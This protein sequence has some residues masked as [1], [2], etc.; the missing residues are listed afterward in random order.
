MTVHNMSGAAC[1]LLPLVVVAMM[2][3]ACGSGKDEAANKSA[4]KAPVGG[5]SFA[6][7]LAYVNKVRAGEKAL[8]ATPEIPLSQQIAIITATCEVS[9]QIPGTP[10]EV[11]MFALVYCP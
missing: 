6:A 3:T 1:R 8:Y 10:S 5:L 9:D 4:S 7:Q 2:L 11:G